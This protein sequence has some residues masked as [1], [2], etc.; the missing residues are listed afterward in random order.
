MSSM[1]RAI[2]AAG[3]L[4]ASASLAQ[5]GDA[6]SRLGP[7]ASVFVLYPVDFPDNLNQLDELHLVARGFTEGRIIEAP[8]ALA[9]EWVRDPE[10]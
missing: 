7:D 4:L 9:I 8:G 10:S 6:I 3:A 1:S 2:F 5:A